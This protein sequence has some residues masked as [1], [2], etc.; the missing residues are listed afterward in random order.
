MDYKKVAQLFKKFQKLP[1]KS[2]AVMMAALSPTQL[3]ALTALLNQGLRAVTEEK[4]R[5]IIRDEM[6][7]LMVRRTLG[8]FTEA[9]G[10]PE[11]NETEDDEDEEQRREKQKADQEK[12][13]DEKGK[14]AEKAADEKEKEAEKAAEPAPAAPAP[15][16]EKPEEEPEEK[17]A[18]E[19]KPEKKVNISFN[20]QG[21]FYGKTKAEFKHFTWPGGK[22]ADD[23][24]KEWIALAI[25]AAEGEAD[26][27]GFYLKKGKVGNVSGKNYDDKDIEFILNYAKERDIIR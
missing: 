13:Q 21:K 1:L 22:E 18:G 26:K 23:D 24:E 16:E 25:Q 4:L 3:H 15:A 14:E 20:K 9:D 6:N 8:H 2:L 19:K 11:G 12:A 10:D 17:P 27:T 5:E 7:E